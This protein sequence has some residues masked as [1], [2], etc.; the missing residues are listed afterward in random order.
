M[1]GTDIGGVLSRNNHPVGFLLRNEIMS[2]IGTLPTTKNSNLSYKPSN[3]GTTICF[4]MSFS[5]VWPPSLVIFAFAEAN[6]CNTCQVDRI[7]LGLTFILKHHSG[8]DNKV[9]NDFSHCL[10]NLQSM[11][12]QV[13][14]F[15]C[16]KDEYTSYPDSGLSFRNFLLATFT[17]GRFCNLWWL[18]FGST[19]HCALCKSI[20][21]FRIR[22]YMWL[23]CWSLLSKSS[24]CFSRWLLLL[25]LSPSWCQ[26]YCFIVSHLLSG[27]GPRTKCVSLLLHVLHDHWKDL[28]MDFVQNHLILP[29][30]MT[31]SLLLLTAFLKWFICAL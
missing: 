24:L 7:S 16:L 30:S 22:S 17:K 9:A 20:W 2:D 28:T 8:V 21:D 11:S 14:D 3:I 31:Q 18:S 5:L 1:F 23:A 6:Q 4:P 27:Q 12:T 25:A 19:C 10:L 29:T 26:S 13:V 15:E